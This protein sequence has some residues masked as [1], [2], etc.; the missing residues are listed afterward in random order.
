M[1]NNVE[2]GGYTCIFIQIYLNFV[3]QKEK[4]NLTYANNLPFFL[5]GIF[6]ESIQIIRTEFY[7]NSKCHIDTK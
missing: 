6:I 1:I 4:Y 3:N 5:Y 2:K 7:T